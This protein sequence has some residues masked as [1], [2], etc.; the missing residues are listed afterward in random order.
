M[1]TIDIPMPEN[2]ADCPLS[3]WI[4]SGNYEGLMMCS[5]MEARDRAL[6]LREPVE[7]ITANYLVE[8]YAEKR[9]EKCPIVSEKQEKSEEQ[10]REMAR[11]N[12]AA[13]MNMLGYDESGNPM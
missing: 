1:I 7:D 10:R 6:V 13:Q 11:Q 5:A 4:Q 8:E 12:W 2:C 9:P 3:Y